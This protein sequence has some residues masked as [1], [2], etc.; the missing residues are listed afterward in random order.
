MISSNR[1]LVFVSCIALLLLLSVQLGVLSFPP[2][3]FAGVG[4]GVHSDHFNWAD[5]KVYHPVESY[6]PLPAPNSGRLPSVQHEFDEKWDDST[7]ADHRLAVKEAFKRCWMSYRMYAWREDELTPKSGVGDSKFG[8]WGATLVDAL[9]TLWIMDMKDEFWEAVEAA[10]AIDFSNSTLKKIN[11]F[12]T[13]IRYL[14]GFLSA[15]DLSDDRRLLDKALEVANMM[16]VAFDTPNRMPILRFNLDKSIEGDRPKAPEEAVL[17]EMG[18]FTLEFTRLTQITGDPKWYDA[19]ARIIAAFGEQ[20]SKTDLPGMWPLTVNA[21]KINFRSGKLFGLGSKSDSLYEYLIKAHALLGGSEMYSQ[22]Y[23]KSMETAIE[24]VL[25]RP[26][27][28]DGSNLL[29]AGLVHVDEDGEATLEPKAEH[30][31]CFAGG[32]FALGGR[33]LKNDTHIDIGAKLTDGCVWTYDAFPTGI[34]PEKFLMVPCDRSKRCAWR[35]TEWH[36][37]VLELAGGDYDGSSAEDIINEARLP[38][39]FSA[40]KGRRYHLRPEALESLFVLYRITGD[41]TY[42]SKAWTMFKNIYKHTETAF[43]NAALTDITKPDA[44]KLDSMESFWFA[45]TL[46]YAFLIF[47]DPNLISL[48]EYVLNTEAHPLKRPGH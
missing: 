1:F 41:K 20:Q 26:M 28:P 5:V 8:G 13:N 7:T 47:S 11:L 2:W 9:D 44:P 30:L 17:A 32:M 38:P 48:D 18:S 14:G 24:Q 15:Y 31:T 43:A 10:V 46:K 16:Y 40:I 12:E 22:L 27:V 25:F 36:D 21:R 39:G 29:V 23:I 34:M 45:E 4:V 19:V 3:D 33:L 6:E 37:A 42:Q 35:K